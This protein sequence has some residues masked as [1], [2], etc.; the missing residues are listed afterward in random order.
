MIRLIIGPSRDNPETPKHALFSPLIDPPTIFVPTD[1]PNVPPHIGL[2]HELAHVKLGHGKPG[3]MGDVGGE[4]QAIELEI[5]QLMS[6]GEWNAE[7]K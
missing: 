1:D 5:R 7:A 6:G 2:S 4:Y 3:M